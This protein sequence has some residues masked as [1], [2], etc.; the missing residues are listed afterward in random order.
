MGVMPGAPAGT[1]LKIRS[2]VPPLFPQVLKQQKARAT[3]KIVA[4]S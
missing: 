4:A 2:V 1:A 3:F